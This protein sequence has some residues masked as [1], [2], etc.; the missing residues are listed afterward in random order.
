MEELPAADAHQPYMGTLW[1]HG[2]A[3][4]GVPTHPFLSYLTLW[5]AVK[6]ST[7]Q[8]L[9][10]PPLRP[11]INGVSTPLRGICIPKHLNMQP[12]SSYNIPESLRRTSPAAAG[13]GGAGS[14]LRA[15]VHSQALL[16]AAVCAAPAGARRP[17]GR[18]P[19]GA[20]LRRCGI[21]PLEFIT[22]LN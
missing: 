14:L 4:P 3:R 16:P 12:L 15:D 9:Y 1:H 20:H 18:L 11:I 5:S 13:G 17:L 8:L 7:Y 21:F 2:L 6:R 10:T 19:L 22:L